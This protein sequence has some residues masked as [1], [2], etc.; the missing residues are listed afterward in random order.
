MILV[1]GAK[2]GVGT[3]TATAM[4]VRALRGVGLDAADGALAARLDR[5]AVSLAQVALLTRGAMQDAVDRVVG[6]RLTLL[7]TPECSFLSGPVLEFVRAV[8]Q[9]IEVVADGGVEPPPE[10]AERPARV[11][12]VSVSENSV[13]QYHERR[14]LDRFPGA[15]V[16][17]PDGNGKIRAEA[18]LQALNAF[19]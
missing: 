11:L 18:V 7:W 19:G 8:D 3:T 10:L 16:L 15:R 9:R 14:L 13:A 17:H 5:P 2:G 1:I 12:V 4:I 6:K